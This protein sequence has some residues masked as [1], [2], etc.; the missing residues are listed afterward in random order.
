MS[1]KY[2]P[3]LRGKQYDL[4]AIKDIVGKISSSKK[5]C[6]IIEP[7]RDNFAAINRTLD[8]C[9]K[10]SQ[11][12]ALIFNPLIGDLS[13]YSIKQIKEGIDSSSLDSEYFTAIF[14]LPKRTSEAFWEQ[15]NTFKRIGFI[16]NASSDKNCEQFRTLLQS[17]KV[18]IVLFLDEDRRLKRNLVENEIPRALIK[19]KFIQRRRNVDYMETDDELFTEEHMYAKEDGYN[20]FSDYTLMPAEY[21]EGGWLPY[22]VAIHLSYQN[23]DNQ[24]FVRHFVSDS[25]T[26]TSDIQGKFEEA[27]NKALAFFERRVPITSGIE[28]LTHCRDVGEYPGLGVL[29]KISIMHHLELMNEIDWDK[30]I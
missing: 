12:I 3:I 1:F 25:N 17:D 8:S 23:T 10:N 6:P 16:V 20:G 27:L 22:A 18:K 7:V 2:Y 14:H 11:D 15:V 29:K 9:V 5:I 21:S 13:E 30:N 24:I 26:D 19:D 28:L 4:L